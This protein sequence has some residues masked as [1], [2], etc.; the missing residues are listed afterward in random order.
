M[1]VPYT[2]LSII[3]TKRANVRPHTPE[4]ISWFVSSF[5]SGDDEDV[6]D[7]QMSAWLMAVCLNGMTPGETA[8]LTD[9]MV[10]SGSTLDPRT[11][12]GGAI[13]T[14]DKH[15]TGGVGDKV[16]LILAPLVA[17]FGVAV[18]MMA[19]RGLEHTGGTIDKLNSIPGFD[20]ELEPD[21]F[22]AVLK[23]V[24]CAIVSPGN[25]MVPADRKMYALRDV[26]GTVI[27]LPLQTA[28]IM[29]KKIAENPD[30]LVLDVKFGRAA[31]QKDTAAAIELARS[32][33]ETG[34][35]CGKTTTAF[36]TRMDA[37][38]GYA[39][40]NWIEVAECVDVLRNGTG[41]DDLVN[42]C[43]VEAARMLI[44]AGAVASGSLSEGIGMARENLRNVKAFEK[45][46][47]MVRAQ[48]GDLR[49]IDRPD[50]YPP[51]K[52]TADVAASSD[53]YVAGINALEVG[54]AAVELRAG[55]K[56]SEDSV[57][58]TAGILLH[59]K[60][61]DRVAAGE[62]IASLYSEKGELLQEETLRRVESAFEFSSVEVE[63]PPL[64]THFVTKEG[65][66]E[67][68][69]SIFDES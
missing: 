68:E 42:L 54:L 28:S 1:S 30:S 49:C 40:G 21:R 8:A 37:P 41:P 23:E 26:T 35:R 65:A 39:V 29:S 22:L 15:S 60:V 4:E 62:R 46:R 16:S 61:G 63:I 45:F 59:K 19:G 18:P 36:V 52:F 10:R 20:T 44:Q 14:A 51:A 7:Y 57:D 5:A 55:R 9:A 12:L 6:A 56:R 64:I 53:G 67:F 32:M 50:E 13:S 33:I 17:S 31:F 25:D 43:L 58:A 24:G 47:D 27:S 34:E 3:K 69:M 66:D 48:G 2:P 38:V 11:V